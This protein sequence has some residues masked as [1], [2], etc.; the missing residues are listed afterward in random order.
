VRVLDASVT[1]PPVGTPET[2]VTVGVPDVPG[3]TLMVT[4]LTGVL[5]PVVKV[6]V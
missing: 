6:Y 1:V 3:G 2:E 5:L 4:E